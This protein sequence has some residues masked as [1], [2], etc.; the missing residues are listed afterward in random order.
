MITGRSGGSGTYSYKEAHTGNN[1]VLVAHMPE[2]DYRVRVVLR[3]NGETVMKTLIGDTHAELLWACLK[4]MAE[5]LKWDD[6]MAS[7]MRAN[8]D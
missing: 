3:H 2:D 8:G 4:R 6:R 1:S 7:E 5:D